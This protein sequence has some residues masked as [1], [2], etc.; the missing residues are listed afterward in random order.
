MSSRFCEQVSDADGRNCL[1]EFSR[2]ARTQFVDDCLFT[3]IAFLTLWPSQGSLRFFISPKSKNSMRPAPSL[4][5]SA[6]CRQPSLTPLLTMT[7][8][9]RRILFRPAGVVPYSSY[10]STRALSP[11]CSFAVSC[12]ACHRAMSRPCICRRDIWACAPTM[13]CAKPWMRSSGR[14]G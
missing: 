3:R 8:P 12:R 14:G 9:H 11:R 7:H 5:Q 2:A 13:S 1:G 6:A 4:S 10:T